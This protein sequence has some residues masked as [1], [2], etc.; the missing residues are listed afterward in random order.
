MENIIIK[1]PQKY[2]NTDKVFKIFLA[3]TCSDKGNWQSQIE[4]MMIDKSF[5]EGSI[6]S[7]N[8]RREDWPTDKDLQI[9]QIQW[10][11]KYR[12]LA[13]YIIFN[14]TPDT[15]APISLFELGQY[16][17]EPR[18]IS[19]FVTPEYKHYNNI[20]VASELYG[21]EIYETNNILEI[22]KVL[23]NHFY[24]TFPQIWHLADYAN[25]Y[26]LSPKCSIETKY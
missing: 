23:M 13:D 24:I 25:F 6:I 10:E 9:E 17:S 26:E 11:Y 22:W 14:I 3:G 4:N 18:K 7:F 21:F 2:I 19:V 1:A 5:D 12:K 20:K 8:P 15:E 16:L